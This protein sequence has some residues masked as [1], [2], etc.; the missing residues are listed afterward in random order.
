M[1]SELTPCN[2]CTL[3]QITR[4][5]NERGATVTQTLKPT[6]GNEKQGWWEITVSDK[7]E[8]VAWLLE[9]PDRC[10]C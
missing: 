2:L 3:N 9:L 6:A 7:A 10:V 5:A 8:P 4:L 1:V